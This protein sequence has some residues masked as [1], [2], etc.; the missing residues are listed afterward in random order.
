MRGHNE[1]KMKKIT[2]LALL[3]LA[4][5]SFA[6]QRF[7]PQNNPCIFKSSY[8]ATADTT[9]YIASSMYL[10]SI[11]VSSASIGGLVTVYN[12]TFTSVNQVLP[13][14]NMNNVGVWRVN[15]FMSQG[16]TYTTVGNTN[17]VSFIYREK[18]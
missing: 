13:T 12:S 2:A 16:I 18:E 10:D 8:T 15:L 4:S 7:V 5:V 17:G 11:V 9:K 1:A 14:I 6:G 3:F